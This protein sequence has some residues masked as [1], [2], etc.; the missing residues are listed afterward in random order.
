[1]DIRGLVLINGGPPA[2]GM[3][4]APAPLALLDVA[5]MSALERLAERL[6]RQGISPVTAIIE[7]SFGYP[8]RSFPRPSEIDC[9][10]TLPDRFWRTAENAFN[11]LAQNGAG[12]VLVIRLG[13]Y[14]E[15]DFE[16]L[17][18]F[19]LERQ[20][21]VSRVVRGSQALEIFCLSS[22]RRNDA[23]SLFRSRLRRCRSECAPFVHSGYFNPLA[24]S[25]DLRQFGVDILTL[26]AET[27]PAGREI[28]PGIWVAP[29]A[30]IEKGSRILAPA[31]IGYSARIRAGAVI[32]RCTAIERHAQVD[33][34]TMVENSTVLPYSRLGAGLDLAHSVVG[35][36]HIAN[37]RRS[38][39]VEVTDEKLLSQNSGMSGQ[40][41]LSTVAKLP[42]TIWRALK[43]GALAHKPDLE[44]ALR[45]PSP[46]LDVSTCETKAASEFSPNLVI[47]RRYGDQ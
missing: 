40:K 10:T 4:F 16:K 28:K 43:R 6:R 34:G 15:I 12:L 37:L 7:S 25:G 9:R 5:G 39:T 20:C 1:M 21:R 8:H 22:F 42:E 45:E 23:A 38:A 35:M 18:Q 14:A 24:D 26:K 47:A 17:V 13:A 31:F 27:R 30:T 3:A 41:L 33:C 2:N 19:H 44:D 36:G 32:T 46:A 11:D 29:R